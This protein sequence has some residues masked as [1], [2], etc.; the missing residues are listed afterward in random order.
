METRQVFHGGLYRNKICVME[1]SVIETRDIFM[2]VCI[3]TRNVCYGGLY[4]N[5]RSVSLRS[6]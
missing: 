2:E 4:R 1:V 6:I 3:E 5:Q